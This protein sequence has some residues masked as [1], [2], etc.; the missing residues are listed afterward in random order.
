MSN[1]GGISKEIRQPIPIDVDRGVSSFNM[2]NELSKIKIS[3]PFNKL[4]RNNEYRENITKMLLNKGECQPE[5]LELTDDT[6]TIFLGHIVEDTNEEDVPPF[7]VSLNVH[8]MILHNSML[9]S[10]AYLT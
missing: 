1:T 8:D 3:I 6:P 7:Y 9:D 5:T 4:L 10:C 2:Q